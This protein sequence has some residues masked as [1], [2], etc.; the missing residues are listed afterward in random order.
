MV[1]VQAAGCDPIVEGWRRSAREVPVHPDP[2]TIAVSI[3]DATGGAVALT[4]IRESGGSA[5]AVADEAIVEAMRVL[6]RAGIVVEPSSAA[7]VAAALA[8]AARGDLGEDEDVVCVLTGAGVKWPDA[9]AAAF[10]PC[11]LSDERP[12][13]V[14]AWIRAFDTD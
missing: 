10:A 8:L 13:A 3:A 12:E 11:E 7:S 6:A 5:E 4:A 2:R 14:R 9:L 1:A